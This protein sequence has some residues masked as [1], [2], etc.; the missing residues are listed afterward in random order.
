MSA[1][2]FAC[3]C[4]GYYT[5]DGAPPGTFLL[6]KVCWWEDDPVQFADP[7][8]TG[9]ANGPSLN[10]AKEFFH[11]IGVSDPELKGCERAPQP[12]EMPPSIA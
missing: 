11:A 10:Q 1:D 12:E 3:P 2:R 6:C 7:N 9:G 4:C 8:Y 5:L